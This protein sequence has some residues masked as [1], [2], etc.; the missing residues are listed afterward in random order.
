MKFAIVDKIQRTVDKYVHNG[1]FYFQTLLCMVYFAKFKQQVYMVRYS[2]ILIL[3]VCFSCKDENMTFDIGNKNI[4]VKTNIQYVDTLTVRSYTVKMDSVETSGLANPAIIVGKYSDPAFGEVTA[5]SFFRVVLP[6]EKISRPDIAVFDSLK[7]MLIYNKYY[8]GD[9]TLSYTINVHR[10]N[11]VLK[12]NIDGYFYNTSSIETNPELFG[13]ANLFPKP[14]S[15][16]TVWIDLDEAFGNELFNLLLA[17][18]DQVSDNLSFLNYFKGLMLSYS[19]SNKAIIGFKF[20]NAGQADNPAMRL[21][22]HY[23]D[24]QNISKRLDFLVQSND[25]NLQF[26]KYTLSNSVINNLPS[27]QTEKLPASTTHNSSYLM[28]GVGLVTRLEIPYLKNLSDFHDNIKIMDA[29]LEFKPVR[30]SYKDFL[31]PVNISLYTSDDRNRFGSAVLNKSGKSQN[32]TLQIDDLYQVNTLYTLDITS[33]LES[34]LVEEGNDIP[35]LLLT[36]SPDN[37]YLTLDRLILGSSLNSEDKLKLKVYY[38]YY[39]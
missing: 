15:S 14:N 22:Y 10:L 6:G 27:K 17:K 26:N 25:I 21:Y 12:P 13:S 37:L 1:I 35:T 16:D 20:P 5:Q 19:E 29:R 23:Y 30:D 24:Y 34:K 28:A 3:L 7:L 36:V 4:E 11:K 33:F 31:L 9:T 32:A 39:Q 18:D 2:F 38:V 8:T